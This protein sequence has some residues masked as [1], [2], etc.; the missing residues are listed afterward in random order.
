ME[1]EGGLCG[2]GGCRPKI[3]TRQSCVRT[4][5]GMIAAD[6]FGSAKGERVSGQHLRIK[7]W[8]GTGMMGD[9]EENCEARNGEKRG[10]R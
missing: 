6:V 4:C 10:L 7:S 1:G 5:T 3:Q 9:N 2:C 8:D